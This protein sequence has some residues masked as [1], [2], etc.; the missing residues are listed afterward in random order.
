MSPTP[1]PSPGPRPSR[2][3]R[4]LALAAG[5]SLALALPTLTACGSQEPSAASPSPA[6]AAPASSSPAAGTRPPGDV[7]GA[8]YWSVP[9]DVPGWSVRTMDQDG[10]NQLGNAVG[11]LFTTSQD[12]YQ[13]SGRTDREE[14]DLQAEKTT[15][16]YEG[17][18]VTNVSFSPAQDDLTAVKDGAGNAIETRH[19]EWTYTGADQQDYRGTMYLRVFTTTHVPVLMRVMYA[20]P[21]GA[22]S[23]TELE[24]LMKGTALNDPGPADMDG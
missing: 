18:Q 21:A 14:T 5:L 12:T 10:K 19:L 20:C 15:H 13:T 1:R 6:P 7:D 2:P 11:C 9:T 22:Y 3:A 8:P 24:T 16:S 17:S 23:A 4:R